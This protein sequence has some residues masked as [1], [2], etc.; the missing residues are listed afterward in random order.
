MYCLD[1]IIFY[2]SRCNPSSKQL[3]VISTEIR[4]EKFDEK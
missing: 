2:S 4:V 3:T 1:I